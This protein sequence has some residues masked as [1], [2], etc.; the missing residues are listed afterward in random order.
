MK[1]NTDRY[2]DLAA[3][4]AGLSD[5][6]KNKTGCVILDKN[7]RV[8]SLGSN[9]DKTHPIQWRY[10]TQAGNEK[11]CH[12]HAEI[13]A[14]VR[15]R[16]QHIPHTAIVVRLLA[17]GKRS[18]AKPCSICEAALLDSGVQQVYYTDY[19]ADIKEMY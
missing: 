12:L 16:R 8:V 6:K 4:T 5:R 1:V 19:N 15:L 17:N 10:A 14:L 2:F 9:S 3:I 11:A 7:N 13:A 18:M